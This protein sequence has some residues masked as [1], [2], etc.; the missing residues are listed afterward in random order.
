MTA[1][2]VYP[3]RFKNDAFM[4]W[5]EDF[6]GKKVKKFNKVTGSLLIPEFLEEFYCSRSC[7]FG[8]NYLKFLVENYAYFL[9]QEYDSEEENKQW[10]A[11]SPNLGLNMGYQKL[12]MD[13]QKHYIKVESEIWAMLKQLRNVLNQSVCK[14]VTFMVYLDWLGIEETIPQETKQVIVPVK[15]SYILHYEA[16]INTKMHH[17][18]RRSR[19]RRFD[20]F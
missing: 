11:E 16:Q 20:F 17:Y 2:V 6:K 12:G 13:L 4:K 3:N 10:L 15:R 18:T 1:R 9:L 19:F 14:I 7:A 8:G 5:E